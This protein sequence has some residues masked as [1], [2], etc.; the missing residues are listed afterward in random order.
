MRSAGHWEA[1]EE[2]ALLQG[3]LPH[4]VVHC[5]AHHAGLQPHLPHSAGAAGDGLGVPVCRAAVSH[6]HRGQDFQVKPLTMH[7]YLHPRACK[8][9]TAIVQWCAVSDSAAD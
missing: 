3:Q 6:C 4:G 5:D 1:E 8:S 9:I 2:R 7:A